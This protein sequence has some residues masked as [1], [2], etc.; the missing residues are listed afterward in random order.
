MKSGRGKTENQTNETV[1]QKVQER[2]YELYLGR[3]QEPGHE[4][5]DW[6]QAEREIKGGQT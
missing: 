1:L 5:E 4:W 2:A 6:L 3:G